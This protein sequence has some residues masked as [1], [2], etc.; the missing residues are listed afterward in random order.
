[1][2][3]HQSYELQQ[4]QALPLEIKIIKTQRRIREWYN[5]YDGDV[6]VSLSGGKDSTVL[7]HIVDS[8]YHDVPA[9]F[10]DTGLEYP[11]IRQFVK[12]IKRGTYPCFNSDVE[13]LKPKMRFDEVIKRYGYPIVSKEVSKTIYG[14]K[15][16]I[17]IGTYSHN[18]CKL[19]IQSTE[20]GGLY[21]SGKYDYARCL[22]NSRYMLTKWRYLLDADFDISH[23]CCDIMKKE[24][25]SEYGRRTH[26]TPIL[27][28]LASESELRRTAWLQHGCNA[29]SSKRPTSQ[30]LSFWTEQDILQYIKKYN[31]PYCGI[32]G[33]IVYADGSLHQQMI[34]YYRKH[35]LPMD[36]CQQQLDMLGVG[37][38]VT[39]GCN[40]TGCVFCGFGCHLEHPENRYQKLAKTHPK[41]YNYCIGGGEYIDG[42]WQPNSSG[43][44]FGRVLDYIGVNY[45][46]DE[47]FESLKLF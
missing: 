30:P 23:K 25:I 26:R 15:H 18:L 28:T 12:A 3:K 43:L 31:I 37:T 13:V 5:H 22:I 7:K 46:S 42:M 29:F 41:L 10:V 17:S 27:G 33:D 40:R 39:T 47:T 44:G 45:K 21:D 38:L 6:Y 2:S 20:Y 11:E 19:G 9:V 8:I 32:Y 35:D 14:A 1:M 24:P 36:E 16:S 4:L 34:Q